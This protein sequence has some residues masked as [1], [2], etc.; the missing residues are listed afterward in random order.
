MK[1]NTF[2]LRWVVSLLAIAV[3]TSIFV[4]LDLPEN[5]LATNNYV[6]NNTADSGSGSLRQAIIDANSSLGADT[7]VFNIP[8]TDPN[9]HDAG[10]SKCDPGD[11]CWWTITLISTLP[12]ITEALTIDGTTQTANQGDT[13]PGTVGTGGAVGVDDIGLPLYDKPE[14]EINANDVPLPLVI[15]GGASDVTIKGLAIYNSG[16]GQDYA[17]IEA[18]G[19]DG[20]NRL[21]D[22]CLVGV[23]A[24]G[25]DP[26][27]SSR[28]TCGGIQAGVAWGERQDSKLTVQK[29]YVGY[30]AQCGIIG[31]SQG[32]TAYPGSTITVEYC[33]VFENG[34]NSDS[35]DGIDGNGPNN[36]IRYNLSYNNR[37]LS[38]ENAG[39]GGGIELGSYYDLINSNNLIENNTCFGN[40]NHGIVVRKGPR[41]DIIRKNVVYNNGGPAIL[42]TTQTKTTD[43][44]KITQNSLYNNE[45]LGVDLCTVSDYTNG[46][47]VTFNDGSVDISKA[48]DGVD[49]HVIKTATLAGNTL[50]LSGFV[51]S[52]PGQSLFADANVEFFISSYDGT[53]NPNPEVSNDSPPYHGEGKVYLGS[54][55]A[56]ANG[57]F[58]GD[59][60]VAGSGL[61]GGQWITAT[62]T[63]E[64]PNTSEFGENIQVKKLVIESPNVGITVM[65]V[66]KAGLLLPWLW[67][68][69]LLMLAT[70]TGLL[71]R[72]RLSR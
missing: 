65:Q 34:W 45:G 19:G 69:G 33:E 47:G 68:L 24:D 18:R 55:T 3:I 61:V 44:N 71:V 49:Y 58:T 38:D 7:I 32:D 60:D 17:A 1:V 10:G 14:I 8:K 12:E 42:V 28:N 4:C 39:S 59:I 54:L 52:A 16:G 57:N 31:E 27:N 29:C 22:S 66:D 11:A 9:Y 23:R 37:S 30:N 15:S 40:Q 72:R 2:S 67:L 26:G 35:Q 53:I 5:A 48:N 51:G 63:D 21:V 70:G 13:N 20:T 6:V 41:G 25:S 50:I 43:H 64:D 62:A 36:I 46:D 56:D